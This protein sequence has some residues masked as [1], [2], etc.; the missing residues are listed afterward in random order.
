M[1]NPVPLT[2]N[3]LRTLTKSK[4]PGYKSTR[5][6]RK[7]ITAKKYRPGQHVPKPSEGLRG[8]D[9][10]YMTPR[11]LSWSY[12]LTLATIYY[13]IKTEPTFPYEN[14]GMKKKYRI[15]VENFEV[16]L[17]RRSEVEKHQRF[18]IPSTTDLA[19]LFGG[20]QKE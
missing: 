7:K 1:K 20:P 13:W 4:R 10:R 19:L 16:W 9:R 5:S 14:V 12:D 3:V 15:D 17:Q 8:P 18:G 2:E 6:P 11:E